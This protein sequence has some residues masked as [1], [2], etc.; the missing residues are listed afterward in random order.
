MKFPTTDD[1]KTTKNRNLHHRTSLS[2]THP[3]VNEFSE[4]ANC[5]RTENYATI[6]SNALSRFR[7][8]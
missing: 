3:A 8:N 7:Q 6:S 5:G 1:T 2:H 4:G